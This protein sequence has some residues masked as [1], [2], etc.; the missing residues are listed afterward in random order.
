MIIFCEF[1]LIPC[2]REGDFFFWWV[3]SGY[4]QFADSEQMRA[5]QT[6]W[7]SVSNE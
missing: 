5:E 3:V 2:T 7:D 6:T 4:G 1:T